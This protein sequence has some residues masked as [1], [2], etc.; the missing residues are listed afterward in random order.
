MAFRTPVGID[1]FQ[2]L[3]QQGATYVDK[4]AFVR[5]VMDTAQVL[6]ITRPRRFGKTLNLSML[7]YFFE[8]SDEDR[9]PL[10][11]DLAVWQDAEMRAH[12]QR[13]PVVALTLKGVKAA[14]FEEMIDRVGRLLAEETARHRELLTS[15]AVDARDRALLTEVVGGRASAATCEEAL[16][17]LT[18]AL[19]AHHGAKVV[20]LI[21]EYDAPIERA[22]AGG[23][24]DA[25]VGFFRN[26][27]GAGFK[28][29][30]HIVKG[31][32]TG[33]LRIAK[34]SLFSDLNNLAVYTPLSRQFTTAF[35][36]TEPEVITLA[37]LA[38]RSHHLD[39]I[40]RWYNGY[41]FGDDVIYNPWSV[42]RYLSEADQEPHAYWVSTGEHT[43]IDRIFA[44]GGPGSI[45]E[46][47]ALL[48]GGSIT[49]TLGDSVAL[50]DL[51]ADEAGIWSLL[52][53]AG[54]LT[55][56]E[57][58]DEDRWI[59]TLRIPNLEVRGV[60]TATLRRWLQ[61]GV[62]GEVL[63]DALMA[64]VLRGDAEQV[65]ALLGRIVLYHFSYHDIPSSAGENIYH[66]FVLG[67]LVRLE[68]THVVRSN[69]ESGYGRADVLIRRRDGKGPGVVIEIKALSP[70]DRLTPE[71]ALDRALAQ[72]ETRDYPAELRA[73]G[74]DP[75]HRLA[76]VF[77]GKRVYARAG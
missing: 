45:D 46:H 76:I 4:S 5:E 33:V 68:R 12:F 70:A 52:L 72:I 61:A 20:L 22:L 34:E 36:F 38:G 41:R 63:S 26:F 60:Y 55:G 74:I 48:Q 69:R 27:L 64:A 30:H 17:S 67:L 32:L 37:A 39:A 58:F 43:L 2:Q 8:R 21:D 51:F 57:R 23:Y 13:Y 56:E 7:R 15:E 47:K 28:G 65:E 25:A 66:A 19:A 29:N 62:G 44:A 59:A 16:R 6:L 10:F 1:D 50:R 73:E 53:F 24:F 31:L 77:E 11:E 35:G 3:R 9:A 71:Q 42:L 49:R 54:Y 40:R 18:R 75:I 14:S